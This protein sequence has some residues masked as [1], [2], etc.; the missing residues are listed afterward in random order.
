MAKKT[1]SL[2]FILVMSVPLL[3]PVYFMAKQRSLRQE[4]KEKMKTALLQTIRIPKEQLVWVKKNKEIRFKNH[5]FDIK[6]LTDK[7]S[8][9]EATG[10]YD[11]Q[12]DLLH[13][14]LRQLQQEQNKAKGKAFA[15]VFFQLLYRE[16]KPIPFSAVYKLIRLSFHSMEPHFFSSPYIEQ[17]KPPPDC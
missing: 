9:Y 8:C 13:A 1:T 7:G 17:L 10:I 4:A 14:Q 12:E 5:L 3:F 16:E 2:L 6:T 15:A 11:T